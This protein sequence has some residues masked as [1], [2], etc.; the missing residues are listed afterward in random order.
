MYVWYN[1]AM[2][3]RIPRR[4]PLKKKAKV[5]A[6]KYAIWLFDMQL[7]ADLKAR[8]EERH[9]SLTNYAALALRTFVARDKPVTPDEIC[10]GLGAEPI[11]PAEYTPAMK[12][13]KAE[14]RLVTTETFGPPINTTIDVCTV[15]H[16]AAEFCTCA[17]CRRCQHPRQAHW[18]RGCLAGCNCNE[19]RYM[20]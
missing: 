7:V 19:H 13:R 15:C 14:G 4:K 8:A 20:A 3:K 16:M 9:Q 6:K 10:K 1:Y 2:G 5:R 18:A 11:P 17:K 12:R